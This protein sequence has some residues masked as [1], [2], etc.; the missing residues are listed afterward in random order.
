MKDKIMQPTEAYTLLIEAVASVLDCRDKGIESGVLAQDM[1]DLE[2]I[3]WLNALTL[4]NSDYDNEFSPSIFYTFLYEYCSSAYAEGFVFFY[5]QLALKN[6]I[7]ISE[8]AWSTNIGVI[9]NIHEY[10]LRSKELGYKKHW[11]IAFKLP[12][13]QEWLDAFEGRRMTKTSP[14]ITSFISKWFGKN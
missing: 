9:I 5:S 3:N 11:G 6:G 14:K 1:D 2:A 7:P 12:Y 4:F 8:N 10:A 13:S